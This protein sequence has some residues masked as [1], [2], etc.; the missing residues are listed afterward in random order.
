MKRR[1][2]LKKCQK[3]IVAFFVVYVYI[4]NDDPRDK[5]W[6]DAKKNDNYLFLSNFLESDSSFSE[7][8]H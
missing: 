8:L 7:M 5:C 3:L 2:F 1:L 4:H 6:Q